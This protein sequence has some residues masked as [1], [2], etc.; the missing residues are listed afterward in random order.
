M[1]D[2]GATYS[3][4]V[5]RRRRSEP[6]SIVVEL[7]DDDLDEPGA[8]PG[9]PASAGPTSGPT[10]GPG[11]TASDGSD[12]PAGRPGRTVHPVTVGAAH[13]PGAEVLTPVQ[14][15][16]RRRRTAR[17]LAAAGAAVAV[18]AGAMV[19]ADVVQDRRASALRLESPGGLRALDDRPLVERW[20]TGSGA[21]GEVR[22]GGV[23]FP[24]VLDDML[25]TVADDGTATARDLATGEER[26]TAVLGAGTVCAVEG[27]GLGVVASGGDTLTC[28]AD[29]GAAVVVVDDDGTVTRR[30]LDRTGPFA[31]AG[32]QVVT[33][34]D[35][36][37]RAVRVG[38]A[39]ASQV[40]VDATSGMLDGTL[41]GRD[42]LVRAE[43]PRT[44]DVRWEVTLPFMGGADPWQCITYSD[45]TGAED[46]PTNAQ[47]AQVDTEQ[48]VGLWP[49]G[50]DLVVVQGCGVSAYLGTDGVRLDEPGESTMLY[51]VGDRVVRGGG[52]GGSALVERD[53]TLVRDL[54]GSYLAPVATD[55]GS[56]LLLATVPGS[57]LRAT[58]PD[59]DLRWEV[60]R[61][62]GTVYGLTGGA[63][64]VGDGSLASLVALDPATGA[65]LW[66]RSTARDL[67]PEDGDGVLQDGSVASWW[68]TGTAYTDGDV[69]V[70]DT[71]SD[72]PTSGDP[73]HRFVALDLADGSVRW[74]ATDDAWT[75]WPT[76]V[77]GRVVLVGES[78]VRVLG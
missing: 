62:A 71:Q 57:G 53:G 20:S 18:V 16:E 36:V 26:W 22:T 51:P 4:H 52:D 33:G 49:V 44:G 38:E 70:V 32:A 60:S 25:V 10:S 19:V 9:R 59:G 78:A 37:T 56:D 2:P 1:R 69:L 17:R 40:S 23:P 75:G 34:P 76:I 58:G 14:R 39:V 67:P 72:Q 68:P 77:D 43:D 35:V 54:E 30:E 29:D 15:A 27:L 6:P 42:L 7:V 5:R 65:V 74:T 55:G 64:V 41:Q 63:V 31:D 48:P 50:T 47:N 46:G 66:D 21:D 61:F 45:V 73:P 8:P 28:V 11:G 12:S 13:G 24:S 3:A